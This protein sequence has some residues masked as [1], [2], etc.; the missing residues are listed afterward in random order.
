[1]R[2]NLIIVN[3]PESAI[4]IPESSWWRQWIDSCLSAVALLLLSPFL[5]VIAAG[6]FLETG[7]PIVFSQ[8]RVG[9]NGQLFHLLKFR[10]MRNDTSGPPLTV[11]GDRRVTRVGHF[12]RKYKLDE[13]PQLWNVVCAEMSIVGPRPEV[14]EFVDLCK[15]V[16]QSV[17]RVR[18]GITD[19]ASI[20]FHQEEE[21]LAK[22][23]DPIRYYREAVLPAKL[24][25]NIAY[26]QERSLWLDFQVVLRTVFCAAFPGKLDTEQASPVAPEDL[27]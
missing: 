6:I 18:P 24:A 1:M 4:E 27:K 2:A 21:L 23:S 14:A 5:L 22:S 15:P 9:R 3:Q 7:L 17:L 26:L 13:L 10:S 25:M 12:L 19:P 16:W 8:S 11:G 20:A